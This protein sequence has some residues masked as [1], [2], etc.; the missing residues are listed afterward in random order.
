[1]YRLQARDEERRG[2]W[3]Y[4]GEQLAVTAHNRQ[5]AYLATRCNWRAEKVAE[6]RESPTASSGSAAAAQ[7]AAAPS[8]PEGDEQAAAA[9]E[10]GN[11]S[12][13]DYATGKDHDWGGWSTESEK[14]AAEQE[15]TK[16]DEWEQPRLKKRPARRS[17]QVPFEMASDG[18][19][20]LFTTPAGA[21]LHLENRRIQEIPAPVMLTEDPIGSERDYAGW[22]PRNPGGLPRDQAR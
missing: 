22:E 17:N 1:M 15:V 12:R 21:L 11:K 7:K 18:W 16:S 10:N 13:A 8:A 19:G 6:G 14:H 3:D 4:E 9:E 2:A 5:T 20:D